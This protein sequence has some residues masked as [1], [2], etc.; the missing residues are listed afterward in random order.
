MMM[1]LVKTDWITRTVH[2]IRLVNFTFSSVGVVVIEQL[3]KSA[4][5][6]SCQS[7]KPIDQYIVRVH[8]E[9]DYYFLY[10]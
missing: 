1:M 10:Y 4:V 3:T 6:V 7:L 9:E 5:D 8:C 2:W